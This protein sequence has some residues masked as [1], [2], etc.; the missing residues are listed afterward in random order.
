[1]VLLDNKNTTIA[2]QYEKP[3]CL[4]SPLEPENR[5]LVSG[6]A[7]NPYKRSFEALRLP[8]LGHMGD[9]TIKML[10]EIQEG[11]RYVLQTKNEYTLA[12]HGTGTTGMSGVLDNMIEPGDKILVGVMGYWGDKVAKIAQRFGAIVIRMEKSPGSRLSL[13]E[14]EAELEMHRP[15]LLFLVSGE[16][17]TCVYQPVEGIGELCY[18]YDCISII[19]VIATAGIQPIRMDENKIDVVYFNTHKG[20]GGIVG[21]SPVSYSPRAMSK[22]KRRQTLPRIYQTDIT[23]QAEAWYITMPKESPHDGWRHSFSICLL[24]SLREVLARIVEEGIE[25]VWERHADTHRYFT[26]RAEKLGLEHFVPNP[27][28]RLLATIMFKVPPGKDGY[29]IVSYISEKYQIDISPGLFVNMGKVL[30]VG[31]FGNNANR[32]TAATVIEALE[33]A[34]NSTATDL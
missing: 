21:L 10:S 7:A 15:D 24:Y 1:M 32:E 18:K 28:D 30:R 34:L 29:K 22:V 3:E 25:N 4:Q 16:S 19:D 11:L 9:R 20:C 8:M 17:S 14:I 27:E 6:A 26:S 5:L 2:S 23:V 33:S 31:L 12:Y 13:S